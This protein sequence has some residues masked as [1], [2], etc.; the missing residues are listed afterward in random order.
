MLLS[1]RIPFFGLVDFGLGDISVPLVGPKGVR[2][3]VFASSVDPSF[4]ADV[5][6][7]S[8]AVVV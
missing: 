5:L 1:F 3:Q 8:A 7:G 6:V 2:P 4:V